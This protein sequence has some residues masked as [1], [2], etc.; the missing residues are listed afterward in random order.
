LQDDDQPR[1]D[2]GDEVGTAD[3]LPLASSTDDLK[4]SRDTK[5]SFS[6]FPQQFWRRK[7]LRRLLKPGF[8]VALV[9]FLYWFVPPVWQLLHGPV[10]VTHWEKIKGETQ[11]VVGPNTKAWIPAKRISKHVLHAFVAAEDGRFYQHHGLDF[12]EI[13]ASA[14]TNWK[15]GRYA[16]GGSTITQQVVKVA[17]LD[18]DKSIIRKARE[19]VGSLILEVIMPKDRILEWYINLVEF[20]DG[21]YGIKQ[22]C[23]HYFRTK[24]E[25]LSIEQAV[26][27]ALVLPSPNAWSAGLRRKNLTSFGHKRFA[28]ILNRMKGSGFITKSQWAQAL[29]RGDF[30][31]PVHGYA[32][33]LEAQKQNKLICPGSPGCPDEEEDIFD[34]DSDGLSYPYPQSDRG[35]EAL[36]SVEQKRTSSEF[37][38]DTEQATSDVAPPSDEAAIDGSKEATEK[39]S[40]ETLQDTLPTPAADGSSAKG[41]WP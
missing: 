39:S 11:V 12:G 25:L 13:L 34:E 7:K 8:F 24:P 41:Q 2:P 22:G 36:Q 5:L 6:G 4:K 21:V 32:G 31:R 15:K 18:R 30:G 1:S 14:K 23:W 10:T 9:A 17:F 35:S 37:D 19:A 20:G 27:L 3:D 16:R 29:A 40:Q 33:F 38:G 26:H 28:N